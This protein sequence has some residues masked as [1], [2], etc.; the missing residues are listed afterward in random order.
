MNAFRK[1]LLE[2]RSHISQR[3][4]KERALAERLQPFL[5]SAPAEQTAAYSPIGSEASP[6]RY[7]SQASSFLLPRTE[8]EGRMVFARPDHLQQGAFGI[9]EPQGPEEV[10][11][12]LLV[13]LLGFE[14]TARI[15]YG[16][17]YY[18]RYLA[19]HP[20][21]TAIGIAF[22]EQETVLE[23]QP[24]DVPLDAVVTPTRVLRR[25]KAGKDGMGDYNETEKKPGFPGLAQEK[26]EV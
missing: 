15:G 18:D 2:R 12:L 4:S 5:L 11:R 26:V 8:P 16:G 14:K 17:G 9:L 7:L 1:E 20:D 10:P 3:E 6:F 22:D 23:V 13:P 25:L 24:W 19:A 21:C